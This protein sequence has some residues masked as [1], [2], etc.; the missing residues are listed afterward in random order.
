MYNIIITLFSFNFPSLLP[1]PYFGLLTSAS[2]FPSLYFRLLTSASLL[3]P[4]YFSL[5]D[6]PLLLLWPKKYKL[7]LTFTINRYF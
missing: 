6:F 5:L 4:P 2:L 3:P 7:T 1:P